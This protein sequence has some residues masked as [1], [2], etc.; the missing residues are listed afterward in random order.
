M[1]HHEEALDAIR[2]K[3]VGKRLNYEE[4]YS[5]MDEISHDRL[6]DILTT[7]FAASGYSKGFSD[8]E[9]FFL[10][11]AMVETGD[12]LHFK[13]IVADKHSIGGVPGTRTTLIVVPIIAAAGY[14]IPKSSSRAITTPGGTADDMEVL[15]KVDFS[16]EEIYEIVRKTGGCIVWGGSVN[17]APADDEIIKVESPLMY[18]SFDK[19]LVSIMAKKIA[20]GS[21][22][23]VIDLPYGEFVKVHNHKDAEE[24]GQKFQELAKKFDVKLFVNMHKTSEPAGRGVG[25]LLEAR[26][27]IR[28][29]EQLPDRPQDLED[30]ALELAGILLDLCLKDST[31]GVQE[32]VK[33]DFG[34]GREWA[35]DI[36][37]SGQAWK[38]MQAI[39]K[40]Q[41]G[42]ASVTSTKLIPGR[43]MLEVEASRSGIIKAINS[44]N[45]SV[46]AK[47]LGCPKEKRAGIY[48]SK[49]V[50]ESSTRGE[51]LYTLYATSSS[52]LAEAHE[53]LANFPIFFYD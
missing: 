51:L 20:F 22:H 3:L 25:P 40:A 5:I 16:K 14:L 41:G 28:V 21:N 43:H 42:D 15:A 12:Q 19:V 9:I 46:I 11:K 36:L 47:I 50:G 26:E 48:F 13:G 18:E 24:L 10:T 52:A 33:K 27:A 32:K 53:S 49:K 2:K 34:G 35:Q 23:V 39:I 30:K 17:I 37:R 4:I 45:I 44:K 29:L 38:K 31:L 1:D 7:Y 6:G 8:Q